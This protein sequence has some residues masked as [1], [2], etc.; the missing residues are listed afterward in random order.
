MLKE[1]HGHTR[2]RPQRLVR[3]A[4]T[5]ALVL[6]GCAACGSGGTASSHGGTGG[7]H[8][9]T[10]LDNIK[11]SGEIS[12]CLAVDPPFILQASDGTWTSYDPALLRL[13][14]SYYNVR[15]KFVAVTWP[16]IVSALLSQKCDII[17]ADLSATP[18]RAKVIDFTV[19]FARVGESYFLL[20]SNSKHIQ[21]ANQ[22]NS[23]NVTIAV[24]QG[25]ADEA[26]T[27][28]HMPKA[29]LVA[30][31]SN[32]G[33]V[34]NEVTSG[35]ADAA[36]F[37]SM[38][39]PYILAKYHNT[40]VV[41]KYDPSKGVFAKQNAGID[42]LGVVWGVRKGNSDLVDWLNKF[43]NTEQSNGTLAKL[44]KDDITQANM[45]G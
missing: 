10:L 12:A 6:L 8:G 9:K 5:S 14:Q 31:Q 39:A 27:K 11:S 22:L 1:L 21:T 20:T 19:P 24:G 38:L 23:S 2:Q 36:A 16:T 45:A 40:Y 25:G 42:A 18:A 34:M 29:H 28:Q 15:V 43:L 32:V 7:T 3:R 26:I 13:L 4:V 41:P 44:A 30:I 17:G 35:R 37:N 33:T